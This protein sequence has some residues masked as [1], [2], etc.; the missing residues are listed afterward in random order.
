[1][2]DKL[3]IGCDSNTKVIRKNFPSFLSYLQVSYSI[4]CCQIG[5]LMI[6]TLIFVHKGNLENVMDHNSSN[7]LFKNNVYIIRKNIPQ[8]II[9]TLEK[10]Y[11]FPQKS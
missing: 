6:Q 7:K 4:I 3:K 11:N 2:D 8:P 10:K 1:M 5:Y 9:S